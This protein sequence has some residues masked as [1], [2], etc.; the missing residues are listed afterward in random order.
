MDSNSQKILMAYLAQS[1]SRYK[2][3][4]QEIGNHLLRKE[5][6]NGMLETAIF[7]RLSATLIRPFVRP[8]T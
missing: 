6:Q 1:I 4:N 7:T 5:A 2:V 8:R 3:L